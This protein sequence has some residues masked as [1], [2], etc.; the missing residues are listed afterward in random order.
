MHERKKWT[1]SLEE[2]MRSFIPKPLAP[3]QSIYTNAWLQSYAE[4]SKNKWKQKLRDF[5]VFWNRHIVN[6]PVESYFSYI[7]S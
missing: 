5:R 4:V 2:K 6:F 7:S 1:V 3:K